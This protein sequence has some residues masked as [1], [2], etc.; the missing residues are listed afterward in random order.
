MA[1]L[2]GGGDDEA[3]PLLAAGR[4]VEPHTQRAGCLHFGFQS[5]THDM[6]ADQP[7]Q[8]T[9]RGQGGVGAA[10]GQNMGHMANAPGLP[11]FPQPQPGRQPQRLRPGMIVCRLG[12]KNF[13]QHS[14]ADEPDAGAWHGGQHG[15][16]AGRRLEQR[17][18]PAT[19]RRDHV[20]IGI[21]RVGPPC[22]RW[23]VLCHHMRQQRQ[24][25]RR[26][27]LTC[28]QQ[29]NILGSG[30]QGRTKT[31]PIVATQRVDREIV[32]PT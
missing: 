9:G 21:K 10:M 26:H 2:A 24:C 3:D 16:R 7:G 14:A 23:L 13:S 4:R 27:Q 31:R 28:F 11:D 1:A 15:G 25:M 6:A 19:I 22:R 20:F 32:T 29:G 17:D 30:G 12:L 8:H 18:I 5:G